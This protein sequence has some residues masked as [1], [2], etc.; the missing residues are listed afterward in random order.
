[1]ESWANTYLFRSLSEYLNY[2]KS[3]GI[4]LQ[5]AFVL[6]FIYYN[7]PCKMSELTE[8]SMVSAAATSQMVDRLE[9]QNLVKRVIEQGDRRVRNVALSKQGIDFVEQ[10]IKARRR[11]IQELPAEFTDEQLDRI[12]TALQL[13]TSIHT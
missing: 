3:A 6:T 12:S 1:M 13:L 8:H 11:W 2:A 9:N 10:S 5:Q 7:G 4:S